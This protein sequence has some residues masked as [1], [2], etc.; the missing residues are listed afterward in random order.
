MR[1]FSFEVV[2]REGAAARTGRLV[3]PGGEVRTPA[4]MPVGTYGAVKGVGPED[5]RALG[6]DMVLSNTYHLYLAPGVATVEALGGVG[7]MMGWDGPVLTDSGGYQV[8]SLGGLARVDDDGVTFRSH[9]DGSSHRFTPESTVDAQARMGVD[10]AMVLDECLPPGR[11]RAETERSTRRTVE[12]ARR[13]LPAR[14][15]WGDSAPALFGIVQ[16]GF[17]P[18]LRAACAA[19]L[20]ELPF[21]GLA[22]GG[23]S[24][25]EPRAQLH[26]MVACTAPLLPE[27]RPRYLM[28][29]GY[30]DDIVL[31]VA[32]GV[33]LFD[34]VLPTRNARNGCLFT[35]SGRVIVKHAAHRDDPRPPDPECGCPVCRR[36]SRGYL[37]HLFLQNE[38]LGCRL[39]TLHNL[40]FYL[41]GMRRIR[42]AIVAGTFSGMVREAEDRLARVPEPSP[43][44]DDQ[45]ASAVEGF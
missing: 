5:L 26:E 25:G 31:A 24:V 44:D 43:V 13:S 2:A 11:G 1:C 8:F 30:L 14:D 9:R 21:D 36:F 45:A 42:E 29:V 3:L 35:R 22:I 7:K 15:R 10:V 28:G 40:W 38:M 19:E 27:D 20:R 37:R 12:W 18:D 17:F 23:L 39:N 32:R 16:G 6:A 34:C 41:D 4:F 33:D